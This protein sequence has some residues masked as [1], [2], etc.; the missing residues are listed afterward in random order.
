MS[1]QHMK[2]VIAALVVA[3]AYLGYKH[4]QLTAEPA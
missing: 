3:V 2:W 1:A 4:Y